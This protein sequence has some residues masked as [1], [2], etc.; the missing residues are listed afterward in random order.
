MHGLDVR[1]EILFPF[2]SLLP[3]CLYVYFKG[4]MFFGVA[5]LLYFYGTCLPCI[6][7]GTSRL[8]LGSQTM[9]YRHSC[10]LYFFQI[11]FADKKH[12]PWEA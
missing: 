10:L 1:N 5:I 12:C 9:F 8:P 3:S 4:K 2:L 7:R 6:T 11:T